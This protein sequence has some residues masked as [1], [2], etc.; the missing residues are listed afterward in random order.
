MS[1]NSPTSKS[2]SSCSTAR[3][4]W[5]SLSRRAPLRSSGYCGTRIALEKLQRSLVKLGNI[6]VDRCVRTVLENQQ[7]GVTYSSFHA[8]CESSGGRNVAP[9]ECDEGRS[10]DPA[11][12]SLSIMGN[13]GVRMLH[14]AL[15]RLRGSAPHEVSQ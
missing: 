2:P 11:K 3:M 10:F 15:D 12:L 7:F 6:L 9:P 4:R 13:D 14:E 5:H 8:V 1:A